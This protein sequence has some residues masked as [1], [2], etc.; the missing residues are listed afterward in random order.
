MVFIVATLLL[1]HINNHIIHLLSTLSLSL[2]SLFL[3]IFLTYCYTFSNLFPSLLPFH[4]PTINYHNISLPLSL[5]LPLFFAL[6]IINF[7]FSLTFCA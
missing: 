2:Y 7:Q 3:L 1:R 6:L 4:L 5:H